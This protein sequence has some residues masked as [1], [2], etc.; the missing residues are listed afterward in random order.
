MLERH[1]KNDLYFN[2]RAR[3]QR[4]IGITKGPIPELVRAEEPLGVSYDRHVSSAA[5]TGEA[6]RP[7]EGGL[8]KSDMSDIA[9]TPNSAA[10]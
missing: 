9:I 10:Q 7:I 5:L 6:G 4:Q 8:G 3:K 2:E 1:I